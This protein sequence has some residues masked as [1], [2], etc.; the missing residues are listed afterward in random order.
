MMY[1]CLQMFLS[2][3]TVDSHTKCIKKIIREEEQESDISIGVGRGREESTDQLFQATHPFGHKVSLTNSTGITRLGGEAGD[4][5]KCLKIA[6]VDRPAIVRPR[7]LRWASGNRTMVTYRI[8][9][10]LHAV[11]VAVLYE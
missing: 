7:L 5:V 11:A 4:S 9:W 10:H 2:N 3:I 1:R 8:L 6:A